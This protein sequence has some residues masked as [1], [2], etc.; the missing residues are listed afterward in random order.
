MA[1]Q[2]STRNSSQETAVLFFGLKPNFCEL[3]R[4]WLQNDI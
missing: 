1:I 3:D 4:I 2:M